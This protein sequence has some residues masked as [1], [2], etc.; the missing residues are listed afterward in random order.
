MAYCE[1]WTQR[2]RGVDGERNI[3]V[4]EKYQQRNI[5]VMETEV[6]YRERDEKFGER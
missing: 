5:G 2:E 4:I 1:R 6:L 3:E